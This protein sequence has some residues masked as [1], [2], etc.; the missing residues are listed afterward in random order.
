[1]LQVEASD[2][3]RGEEGWFGLIFRYQSAR[4]WFDVRIQGSWF[5]GEH[6]VDLVSEDLAVQVTA[7]WY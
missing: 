1:M 3:E 6:F 4:R 2:L 7:V 5:L